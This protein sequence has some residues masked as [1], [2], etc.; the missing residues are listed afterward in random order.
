MNKAVFLDRDGTIV[1]DMHY[2]RRPEDLFF[3]PGVVD[4]LRSLGQSEYKIIVVTNQSGIARGYFS[5]DTL[6]QIH[7]RLTQDIVSRGGRIDAIY[8]CPHHPDDHCHCRKPDTGLLESAAK[9]WNMEAANGMGCK[10]VLVP[11]EEP[12]IFLLNEP[13]DSGATIDFVS[14]KF[15]DAV[16]WIMM[17]CSRRTTETG[18]H[19]D[20]GETAL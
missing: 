14:A 13:S 2:C 16:K 3:L 6:R 8:F 1:K 9:D 19:A 4:G 10:A 17:D 7:D 5:E 18:A 20:C 12:E 15:N 11:S